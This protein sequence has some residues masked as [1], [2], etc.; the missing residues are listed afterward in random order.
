MSVPPSPRLYLASASPRRRDLLAQ[1]GLTFESLPQSIDESLRPGEVAID[2]VQRVALEKATAGWHDP[3]RQR[4][5]P[6]LA[7][8][9]SVVCNNL[10]LGKPASL[11]QAQEMLTLLSG[12]THEVMTAIVVVQGGR[13][14]ARLVSTSVTFR[15]LTAVEIAA[16]WRSGEPQD[17]AGGYG[18]Q[19]RAALFVDGISGSYSN[20]VGLPLFETARLLES[21]GISAIALLEGVPQ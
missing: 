18:I 20:V 21:F 3:R 15:E 7:A 6:V 11:E 13:S 17:K 10:V 12:R 16:Y 19:G 4:E 8:D 2:Y 1:I 5:L 14:A 9:T